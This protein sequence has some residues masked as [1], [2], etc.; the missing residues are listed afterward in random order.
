MRN[1]R[2]QS[3]IRPVTNQKQK[4]MD[5]MVV[6]MVE[7][8]VAELSSSPH[9]SQV[10]LVPK[11]SDGMRFAVDYREFNLNSEGYSWP[12][13]KIREM[14]A[15]IGEHHPK[16]FCV[17]DLTSGYHQV[18]VHAESR[19]LTAFITHK[20]IYQFAWLPMGVKGAPS[21]FQKLMTSI[22]LVGLVYV[23]CEMYL[24]DLLVFGQSEQELIINLHK[25]FER[26]EN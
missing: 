9:Y 2:S 3:P 11:V 5:E 25:V 23:I 14:F 15:R 26:L 13:P 21:Y 4:A 19:W 24:D 18:E 6:E 10:H 22:V 20:R 12:I 16:Y 17:L 1:G 7:L 8:R